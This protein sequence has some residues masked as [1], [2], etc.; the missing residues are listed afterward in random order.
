[1]V[2]LHTPDTWQ[3]LPKIERTSGWRFGDSPNLVDDYM[4][5]L[6]EELIPFIDNEYRTNDFRVI[7]GMSPT[8]IL[9]LHTFMFEPELFDA[10]YLF[11]AMNIFDLGYKKDKRILDEL[12]EYL[13]KNPE[14]D[15]YL[16]I[17]SAAS[18]LARRP[19]Q[20][21]N[22]EELRS[23]I[24]QLT[25]KHLN[26]K[27]EEIEQGGHYPMA[28]AATISA[29]QF[30]FPTTELEQFRKI[31]EEPGDAL[32]KINTYY[33]E[34]SAAFGYDIYPVT[35][36]RRNVNCLRGIGYYLLG[37]NRAKEAVD[38]FTYWTALS[39]N[40][41]N[42]Y[43]SLADAYENLNKNKLALEAHINAVNIAKRYSD[44]RL[45]AFQKNLADFKQRMETK[46]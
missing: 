12:V 21:A 34:L 32:K 11:A 46:S 39:P 45:A 18:D 17:S 24:S 14:R 19:Q 9:A 41:P 29:I 33:A 22:M 35:D 37:K 26:Y 6:K 20:K 28:M 27:I 10:T 30:S 44:A 23:R 5:F 2:A 7:I 16:Y 38:I 15:G 25:L 1:V 40:D 3:Y 13:G 42:G 8:A 4:K 36:L 43:D 31:V